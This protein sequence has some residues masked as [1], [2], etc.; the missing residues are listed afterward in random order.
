MRHRWASHEI[1]FSRSQMHRHT[2]QPQ[3]TKQNQMTAASLAKLKNRK[4]PMIR[5]R[6]IIK[7]IQSFGCAHRTTPDPTGTF[8]F[9]HFHWRPMAYI[10]A[11][12]IVN[13]KSSSVAND[14]HQR[15]LLLHLMVASVTSMENKRHKTL[16]FFSTIFFLFFFFLLFS[17]SDR[18][19]S[20]WPLVKWRRQCASS[21]P[22][23]CPAAVILSYWMNTVCNIR[24]STQYTANM[25][26]H[27]QTRCD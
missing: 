13:N 27:K 6:I 23:W 20:R 3:Q 5:A 2:H 24:S 8:F 22:N 21:H 15:Y 16:Y 18:N 9:F 1:V 26:R 17:A 10:E 11:L 12:A 14:G 25:L 7:S 19:S 4:K